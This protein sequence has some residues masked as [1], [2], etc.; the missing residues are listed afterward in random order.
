M[1]AADAWA[2][3]MSAVSDHLDAGEGR[4]AWELATQAA[5]EALSQGQQAAAVR[6]QVLAAYGARA[7]G[8]R[9][10][11][12]QALCAGEALAEPLQGDERD[13]LA[14][15]L[16]TARAR[17][18]WSAGDAVSALA[19][20]EQAWRAHS[21]GA[22]ESARQSARNIFGALHG[23]LGQTEDAEQW[24]NEVLR[25][26][27]AAG[28]EHRAVLALGN[29][30]SCAVE[31]ADL[32]RRQ[33]GAAAAVPAYAEAERRLR[34]ARPRLMRSSNASLGFA[35]HVN[36]AHALRS[37]GRLDEAEAA[38]ETARGLPSQPV[39]LDNL[40]SLWQ[41]QLAT[42]RAAQGCDAEALEAMEPLLQSAADTGEDP[43]GA[44]VHALAAELAERR[45]DTAAALAHYKRHHAAEKARATAEAETRA[46]LADLR[47]RL[48]QLETEAESL[49]DQ[50]RRDALT[51]LANRRALDE[52]IARHQAGVAVDPGAPLCV[53]MIDIDHFKLVNDR[54]SHGVGDRVLQ[55]VAQV[56][57]A[58]T[59][60]R[61][62]AVR[63]GGEE[64]V[65]L[66]PGL[67]LP[68]AQARCERL[69]QAVQ[70]L[71]W[72]KVAP[73]LAVTVSVGVAVGRPGELPRALAAA[74]QALYAAKREGRNRVT[75]ADGTA[76]GTS[77]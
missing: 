53:A 38:L 1:S 55:Q 4:Q 39:H 54:H 47:A 19:H 5:A 34:E 50:A 64:F 20:L 51:G 49:R 71:T 29:L 67:A 17:L 52:A 61:D 44:D 73:G 40:W 36:L 77:D 21:T 16:A 59:G 74:D 32:V 37:L 58:Q 60:P 10:A 31:R 56:L 2:R 18:R 12:D 6:L 35:L 48:R 26:A 13:D 9:A 69:R 63:Q 30:A 46:R 43:I 57:Q 76:D 7:C 27:E 3:V 75:V 33:H 11:A 72:T 22:A 8:E 25:G 24:F 62:L 15:S 70:V 23:S 41:F 45:G 28:E 42:L 65:W 68:Q 14:L 66:M